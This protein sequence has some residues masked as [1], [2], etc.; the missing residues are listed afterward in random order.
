MIPQSADPKV[1]TLLYAL[2]KKLENGVSGTQVCVEFLCTC[3]I[4]SKASVIMHMRF[5]IQRLSHWPVKLQG[6]YSLSSMC[7]KHPAIMNRCGM[8]TFGVADCE[9]T[10]GRQYA[11]VIFLH[12]W[13]STH[14]IS[15]YQK[16]TH[17]LKFN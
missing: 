13:A 15:P 5:C 16:K 2:D 4:L 10:L 12:M 14:R 9:S 11:I 7:V 1:D 8:S 3:S 17:N 6:T